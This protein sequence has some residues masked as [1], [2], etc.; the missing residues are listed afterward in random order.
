M[1]TAKIALIVTVIF[2]IGV[3]VLPA[4]INLLA[5]SHTYYDIE[6]GYGARC[7][8]CHADVYEEL[9]ASAYHS[10]VDG[11]PGVSGDEC[12][13]CHRANTTITFG[14]EAHAATIFPC[15]FCHLNSSNAF[16][17]PIAGGFGMSDLTDDTGIKESHFSF[18]YNSVESPLLYNESESCIA[19]HS[20][21]SLD[22][23]FRVP[24]ESTI[25]A[26]NTY[27]SDSYWEIDS[28]ELSEF[29]NHNEVLG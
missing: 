13:S 12:V 19:C 1:S 23:G 11:I 15:S 17:A 5:G 8:K 21:I 20:T 7:I 9:K 22:I 6:E 14:K 3:L 29:T 10:T 28:I 16:N 2:I 25:V 27:S 24:I 4:T 18:V 26:N